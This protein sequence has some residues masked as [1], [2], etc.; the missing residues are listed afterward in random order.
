MSLT[1]CSCQDICIHFETGTNHPPN[2]DVRNKHICSKY[3]KGCELALYVETE[4]MGLTVA[5]KIKRR[6][7]ATE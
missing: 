1:K 3:L 6:G 7:K 4:I 5:C 2:N